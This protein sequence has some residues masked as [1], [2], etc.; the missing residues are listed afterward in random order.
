MPEP[1]GPRISQERAKL[2]A[3]LL[4]VLGACA[5]TPPP[6]A[7]APSSTEPSEEAGVGSAPISAAADNVDASVDASAPSPPPW[8]EPKLHDAPVEA[9][10]AQKKACAARGGEMDYVCMMHVLKC[11]VSYRDA[12]KRCT[13]KSDCH[14]ECLW[15]GK[16]ETHP[17]GTCQETSDPCGCKSS[18]VNGHIRHVCVD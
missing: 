10:A 13:G 5:K 2:V 12:G 18:I 7:V 8:P 4:I 1:R 15:N 3:A 17:V 14:G 16:S 6:D 9:T 11:V